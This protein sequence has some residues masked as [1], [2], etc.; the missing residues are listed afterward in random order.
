MK[1]KTDNKSKNSQQQQKLIPKEKTRNK[2]KNSQ[3]QKKFPKKGAKLATKAK[4]HTKIKILQKTEKFT[5]TKKLAKTH[6]NK[7]VVSIF[8]FSIENLFFVNFEA[9]LGGPF[10]QMSSMKPWAKKA[11]TILAINHN[12]KKLQLRNLTRC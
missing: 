6:N 5:T 3:Q 2:S 12:R 9:D 8:S 10:K 11:L 4:I 1:E 7:G